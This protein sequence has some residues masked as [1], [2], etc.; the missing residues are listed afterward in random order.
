MSQ[1]GGDAELRSALWRADR[2]TEAA[3]VDGGVGRG[4]D[5]LLATCGGGCAA[6]EGGG[7]SD[8]MW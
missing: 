2:E 7:A 6:L 3:G 8:G 4:L 1:A 5:V